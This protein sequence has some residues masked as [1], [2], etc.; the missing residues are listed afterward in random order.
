MNSNLI[1]KFFNLSRPNSYKPII[2]TA[3][4]IVFISIDTGDRT[5]VGIRYFPENR[6]V[7]MF[8]DWIAADESITPAW[9]HWLIFGD[10]DAGSLVAFSDAW[11][12][13][14]NN[15][16]IFSLP[17][18]HNSWIRNSRKDLIIT[19][20]K[21][22]IIYGCHMSFSMKSRRKIIWENPINIPCGGSS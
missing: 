5:V 10:A 21:S 4:D 6:W 14:S 13:S 2:A 20:L 18:S 12:S 16:Q 1:R 7:G 9:D 3:Q 15:C 22:N 17:H 11:S 19:R 8:W